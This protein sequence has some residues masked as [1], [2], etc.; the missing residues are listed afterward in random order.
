LRWWDS[1]PIADTGAELAAD[2]DASA[3]TDSSD[4]TDDGMTNT[5]AD[6]SQPPPASRSRRH[7][8]RHS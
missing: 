5:P 4:D 6:A 1:T 2:G 3:R 7:L 8:P